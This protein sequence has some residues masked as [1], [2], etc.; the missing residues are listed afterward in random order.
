MIR[1]R[2]HSGNGTNWRRN[3]AWIGMDQ[4]DR[5]WGTQ[6]CACDRPDLMAGRS[7]RTSRERYHKTTKHKDFGGNNIDGLSLRRDDPTCWKVDF[8]SAEDRPA[9]Y[10]G[11]NSACDQN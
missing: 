11:T 10:K 3:R 2:D 1:Y 8:F 5:V 7:E 9:T 4:K 6:S